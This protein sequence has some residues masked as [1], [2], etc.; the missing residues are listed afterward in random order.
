[1]SLET[2]TL[3]IRNETRVDVPG[4][5]A[6]TARAFGRDAEADLIDRLREGDHIISSLVALHGG[7]VIGHV[8]FSRLPIERDGDTLEAAALGPMA[9][10]SE[11]QGKGIG[12]ILVMRGLELLPRRGVRAVVVV[13]HPAYY[14]R[15]GFRRELAEPL[16]SPYQGEACMALELETGCLTGGGRVRYP[17]PFTD[18]E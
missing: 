2:G 8:L 14:P 6:L 18:F 17:D 1:V 12:S 7:E 11:H 13:G 16:D 5:R 10:T 15:F 4:I 9:V 3:S